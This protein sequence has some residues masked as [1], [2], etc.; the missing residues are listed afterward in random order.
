M[1]ETHSRLEDATV[2]RLKEH[3]A[4]RRIPVVALTDGSSRIVEFMLERE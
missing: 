1:G 3:D 4:T 2:P